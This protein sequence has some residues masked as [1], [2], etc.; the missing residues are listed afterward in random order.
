M[1]IN[2]R[3]A[4]YVTAIALVLAYGTIGT[5]MLGSSGNFNVK[6]ASVPEALYFTIVTISTVGYGDIV[7]VTDV[8]RAFVIVLI[9][10]GLSI[11]LSAVTVLSGEFLSARVE[12]L[13]SGSDIPDRKKL[14]G[15][16]VLIG[17]DATNALV[18]QKLKTQ[19]RNFVIITGDKP[20]TE[21]LRKKGYP[22]FLEDYTSRA[23]LE[24][25]NLDKATDVVIDLRDSS[26]TVY[27]VLVV[28]KLAKDTK[29]SV[30]VQNAEAE[31][32]LAD[33]DVDSIINPM[34]IAAETLTKTLDRDQDTSA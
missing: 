27:A 22:A 5:Y 3:G 34:T 4:F 32:H 13:Y 8:A 19:K 21:A 23:D 14:S 12:K 2:R 9:I 17:Y 6:V 29:I 7:P 26:K 16:I 11:F 1:D 25:F 20:T 31:T 15:H 30:V 18:A 28:K 10:S 24:K 33:L